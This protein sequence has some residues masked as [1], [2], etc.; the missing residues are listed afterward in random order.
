MSGVGRD[1]RNVVGVF[2]KEP[3]AGPD[4]C[5]NVADGWPRVGE[6]E[7]Q[8]MAMRQVVTAGLKRVGQDVVTADLYSRLF[9]VTEKTRVGVGGYDLARGSGLGGQPAG[10]RAG[11]G[12]HFQA[13][14]PGQRAEHAQPAE[15]AR[16]V[17]RL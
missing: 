9:R 8:G 3:A 11:S 10:H 15:G 7:Q 12:A 16:V 17:A 4:S 1:E 14:G 13:T 6:M 5:R 2:D